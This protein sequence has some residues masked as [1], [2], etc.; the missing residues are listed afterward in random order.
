[1]SGDRYREVSGQ[2]AIRWLV[3][4]TDLSRRSPTLVE[5]LKKRTDEFQLVPVPRR[6]LAELA[7]MEDR[8]R[9]GGEAPEVESAEGSG[10]GEP[11]AVVTGFLSA[12][13]E[14]DLEAALGFVDATSYLDSDGRRAPQLRPLLERLLGATARRELA[15]EAVEVAR[16]TDGAASLLVTGT[17]R[18]AGAGEELSEPLLLHAELRRTGSAPWRITGL[19]TAPR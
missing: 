8:A 16:R 13:A 3:H 19:T 1:M 14:G 11:A 5:R 17:W 7:A 18:A 10:P 15:V 2:L 12:L 6:L 9:R 4:Y